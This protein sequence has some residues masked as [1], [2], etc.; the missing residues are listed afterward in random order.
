[1][2]KSLDDA[3]VRNILASEQRKILGGC[4]IVFSRVFP[5]GES[6]PHMHPLWQ[7]AEQFGAVCTNQLD[8]QVTHV[9]ANSLGT[10]KVPLP[11]LIDS[12]LSINCH[13]NCMKHLCFI[14]L[15]GPLLQEDQWFIL[16]GMNF[17]FFKMK[18]LLKLLILLCY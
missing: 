18:S 4:R 3:D 7:T 11:F 13:C 17:Y 2:E 9:V 15:I 14:R 12:F 6:S 1:M 5:V 10:D 8:E 16:A